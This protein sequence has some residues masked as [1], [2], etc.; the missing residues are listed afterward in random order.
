MLMKVDSLRV[1]SFCE[2]D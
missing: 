2:G 1:L